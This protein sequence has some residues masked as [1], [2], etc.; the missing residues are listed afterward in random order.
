[1]VSSGGGI[2]PVGDAV[3]V[4]QNVYFRRCATS[5]IGLAVA[6]IV[7]AVA[8]DFRGAR[9]NDVVVVRAVVRACAA[10]SQLRQ[11]FAVCRAGALRRGRTAVGVVVR[12]YVPGLAGVLVDIAVVAV[13]VV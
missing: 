12:V 6:I 10:R 11:Q 4:A 2:V 9:M 8:A 7:Y 5:F 13:R 3:A 1:M